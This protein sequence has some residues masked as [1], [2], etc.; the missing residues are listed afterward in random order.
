MFHGV[1]LNMGGMLE[2]STTILASWSLQ[3]SKSYGTSL[4]ALGT[5]KA[6]CRLGSMGIVCDKLPSS[7]LKRDVDAAVKWAPDG[8]HVAV[9]LNNSNV[10]LWDS[11]ANRQTKRDNIQRLFGQREGIIIKASEEQIKLRHTVRKV[12]A[13]GHLAANLNT[14]L[15]CLASTLPNQ[16]RIDDNSIL[17]LMGK[18]TLRWHVLTC[19]LRSL[20]AAAATEEGKRGQRIAPAATQEQWPKLPYTGNLH[21]VS[22]TLMED[23]KMA[24]LSL[25]DQLPSGQRLSLVPPSQSPYLVG[26][27]T[28]PAAG[29]W[30]PRPG[31]LGHITRISNKLVQLGNSDKFIQAFLQEN[32][33]WND[34]Q[35][36]AF[37]ERNIVENVYRWAYGMLMIVLNA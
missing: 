31:N 1:A 19:P 32:S 5:L 18:D 10:Q 25:S 9:G 7:P 8:R 2:F 37:T 15:I 29:K 20:V 26:L 12:V 3:V 34:W 4:D 21:F 16:T 30:T 35:T 28:L 13:Y 22:G 36:I 24:T 14:H 6:R 11:T 33:E 17:Q 27:P 23:E